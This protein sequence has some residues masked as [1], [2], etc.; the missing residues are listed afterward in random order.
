[1]HCIAELALEINRPRCLGPRKK[2]ATAPPS[3]ILVAARIRTIQSHS[4]SRCDEQPPTE[5][6]LVHDESRFFCKHVPTTPCTLC[7]DRCCDGMGEVVACISRWPRSDLT[8]PLLPFFFPT[9][10]YANRLLRVF[11]WWLVTV[12]Y[13]ECEITNLIAAS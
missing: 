1:M 7:F 3:V 8:S 13:I 12:M 11:Y 4:S 10:G 5:L 9:N 6:G 2:K